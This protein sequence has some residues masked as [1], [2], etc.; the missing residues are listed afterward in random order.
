MNHHFHVG[1]RKFYAEQFGSGNPTVV[2]E[3]GSGQAGT[4]DRGWWPVRDTLAKEATVFLY[5]RAG[6]GDSAPAA[7]PRPISEFTADLHAVLG[8]ARMKQPYLLMGSSFG[9]LI[10]TH[11]A[12]QYPKEITGIVLLDSAHP[13]HPLRAL[14]I[15]PPE[16]G[17]ES[18]ALGN[19]RN[20]L[21]RATPALASLKE[22]EGIDLP[23][24]ALQMRSAWDLG[25]IP[26]LVLTA[27]REEWEEGFPAEIAAR[28]EQLWMEMQKE[29]ADRSANSVHMIVRESGHGIHEDAPR[30]VVDAVHRVLALAQKAQPLI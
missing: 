8:A 9:G 5:D 22:E 11:Y 14:E 20:L 1:A 21:R 29:L 24:S 23:Q 27:G 19:F 7:G 30:A 17:R 18:P 3:V 2:I 25:N 16:T 15:L 12:S 26:L 6:T 13:E 28:Y 4:K 10:V